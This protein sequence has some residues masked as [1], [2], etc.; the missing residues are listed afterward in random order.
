MWRRGGAFIVKMTRGLGWRLVQGE[1]HG[2]RGRMGDGGV[3]YSV[4]G[5][6]MR[7]W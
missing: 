6:W 4:V 1:L 3:V 5:D 2:W 7:L